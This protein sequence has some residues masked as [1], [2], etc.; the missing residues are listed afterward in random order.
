MTLLERAQD[1]L[2]PVRRTVLFA[3]VPVLVWAVW[4]SGPSWA[5][6]ALAVF[7]TVGVA[8]YAIDARTHRLPDALTYPTTGV[9]AGFLLCA[10]LVTGS[11]DAVARALL[12]ALI[13]G[14]GYLLLHVINPSG[15]GFA[16][17]KLAVLLGLVT[18]WFGWPTLWATALL[19]FLLGGLVALVLLVTRR[20]TRKTA[21]AFGP[22]MLVG[23]ALALTGT[24]LLAL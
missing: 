18:T 3:A 1:E 8:L 20:A 14:A 16:D 22:F 9:V 7:G 19:P 10:G 2:A 6:P 23:A 12:G 13:L 17:V 5:A 21:I 11:W 4:V 15:L 24:R